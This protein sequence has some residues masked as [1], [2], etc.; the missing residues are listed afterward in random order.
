VLRRIG[1][2]LGLSEEPEE[3]GGDPQT[4]DREERRARLLREAPAVARMVLCRPS[5]DRQMREELAG[6][7]HQGRMVLV[8]LRS[9]DRE[10]GQGL[11]DFLCGV[12]FALR[13][14]VVRAAPGLFLASPRRGWVET[15]IPEDGNEEVGEE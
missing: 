15:W 11:L 14:S 10:S 5:P 13:G 2:L 8:D 9:F 4:E 7:L 3:A 6:A 12:A 1:V